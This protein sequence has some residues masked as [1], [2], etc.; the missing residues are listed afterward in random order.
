MPTFEELKKVNGDAGMIVL[1][2]VIRICAPNNIHMNIE[3]KNNDP[4][5]VKSVIDLLKKTENALSKASISS[6]QRPVVQAA[7][8]TGEIGIGALYNG[9]DIVGQP[10][11]PVPEDY[12]RELFFEKYFEFFHKFQ[13]LK[14]CEKNNND[15]VT[16]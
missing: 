6:F 3:V 7:I 1:E 12:Y 5:M 11:D 13:I 2:D 16:N 14:L 9:R 10:R 8:E 4:S 15:I